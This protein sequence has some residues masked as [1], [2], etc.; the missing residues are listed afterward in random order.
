MDDIFDFQAVIRNRRRAVAQIADH[1]FLFAKAAERLCDNLSDI[2]R[3]FEKCL[4]IGWRGAGKVAE[5]LQSQKNTKQI[6]LYDVV[7]PDGVTGHILPTEIPRPETGDYDAVVV[8][9]CLHQVNDVPGFLTALKSALKPDGVFVC[10][11]FGGQ[12]L[13][14]L[15]DAM[16]RAELEIKGGAGQHIHPMIDHYQFAG[17]LQRAGF[18]LPVADY[19]RITVSYGA[20]RTLYYD[21]RNMGEANAM[22]RRQKTITAKTL[23]TEVEKQYQA[24]YLDRDGRFTATFDILFGIGWHPHDSQQQPARRG[25]GDTSLTEVL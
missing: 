24:Y 11:L 5:F 21:L 4:I 14:E 12:S 20:L 2:K 10:S 8:L 17:L 3:D 7:L 23:F 1:D 13:M 22:T 9:P 25:S 18:A 19:D 16:M 15:R 6:D